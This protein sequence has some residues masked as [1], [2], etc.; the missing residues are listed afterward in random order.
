MTDYVKIELIAKTAVA[1]YNCDVMLQ[2]K[3]LLD[4]ELNVSSRLVTRLKDAKKNLPIPK[5]VIMS[6]CE[7]PTVGKA[8]CAMVVSMVKELS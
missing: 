2:A 7:V 3:K 1:Y 8:V 4:A 6:P 5:F